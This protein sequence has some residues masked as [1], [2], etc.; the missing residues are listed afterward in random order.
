MCSPEFPEIAPRREGGTLPECFCL[1]K[2][3]LE[4]FGHR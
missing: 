3:G 4:L 1:E 2:L